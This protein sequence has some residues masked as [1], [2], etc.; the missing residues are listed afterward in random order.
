MSIAFY[1]LWHVLFKATFIAFKVHYDL[2]EFVSLGKHEL[3]FD[4]SPSFM[5]AFDEDKFECHIIVCHWLISLSAIHVLDSMLLLDPESRITAAE[6]LALPFFSEFREPQEETEAPPYDH[7]LDE[8]EQSVEQWK[9][10]FKW[11]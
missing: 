10:R 11:L 7:S 5:N 4:P 9:S 8:A 1:Q 3:L 2:D 6:G